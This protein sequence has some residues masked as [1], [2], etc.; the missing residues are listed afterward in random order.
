MKIIGLDIPENFMEKGLKQINIDR[1]GDVVV[2]TGKNGAGK[3]RLLEIISQ[4]VPAYL[5][6]T[7]HYAN[8]LEATKHY[9]TFIENNQD[10]S[11]EIS[12]NNTLNLL[13]QQK[14]NDDCFRVDLRQNDKYDVVKF[15]PNK[16]GF[17]APN[18]ITPKQKEIY[19]SKA[20]KLTNIKNINSYVLSYLQQESDNNF[21]ATHQD[22]F[23]DPKSLSYRT[24][25]NNLND[26]INT[27][28]GIRMGRQANNCTLFGRTLETVNLSDGQNVLLQLC[29]LIHAQ[30][31]T[32]DNMILILDEPENHLHPEA[33]IEFIK[34]VKEAL[35]NG[36]IWIATHSI[37]ILSYLETSD[38]WYMKD[39]NIKYAGKNPED[40]LS[41]LLGG[42]E[43]IERLQD[44]IGLPS[45]L[46]ANQFAYECLFAPNT[47]LTGPED[48]QTKQITTLIENL[49]D[50][51]GN[52]RILDFGAGKGRLISSI[53]DN[54]DKTDLLN[55]L[56][57]VAYDE[58]SDD[59]QI[60][61]DAISRVYG[62]SDKRYFNN[63][64]SI[65]GDRDEKSFDVIIMCNVLHEISPNDWVSVFNNESLIYKILSDN[66]YLLVVEDTAIP[67]G[68]RPNSDG[69]FILNRAE[70]KKLFDI[71]ASNDSFTTES[72]NDEKRL[73]AHLI[74]K[75]HLQK[76]SDISKNETLNILKDKCIEDIKKLKTQT[77]YRSGKLLGLCSQQLA[78]IIVYQG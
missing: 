11:D 67:K 1:L 22:Y 24:S 74:S 55:W 39:G 4:G 63:K 43:Q 21:H 69:F 45:V 56:D 60:C 46:A 31:A 13:K 77:D 72:H 12:E 58:Y 41:G 75:Q 19:H 30:G 65:L 52:M 76:I 29:V 28:L 73:F 48:K 32:L 40:V 5:M 7:V 36:Q 42:E 70:L 61:E 23:N 68:E 8:N 37:H 49:K 35:T 26:I 66:G 59:K 34:K 6:T 50:I 51:N 62:T 15:V 57:Y 14:S 71:P 44:F 64:N 47:S 16:F 54:S 25:Y 33:Q 78:N 9:Q 2:I 20:K 3:T 27:F 38:I 53:L 18:G 17:I 10:N